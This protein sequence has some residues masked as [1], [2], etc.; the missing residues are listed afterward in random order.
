LFYQP[1]PDEYDALQA[2]VSAMVTIPGEIR[3]YEGRMTGG[4][5]LAF[6]CI[7]E[8]EMTEIMLH[9]GVSNYKFAQRLA[10]RLRTEDALHEILVMFPGIPPRTPATAASSEP[11]QPR[12][13]L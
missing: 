10:Q 6:R 11:A 4:P 12:K 9:L 8:A 1:T 3:S 7:N 2:S 5:C 13:R